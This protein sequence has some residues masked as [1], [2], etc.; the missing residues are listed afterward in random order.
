[1]PLGATNDSYIDQNMIGLVLRG[2]CVG[3]FENNLHGSVSPQWSDILGGFVEC[4]ASPFNHKFKN[5]HSMFD[6]DIPFGSRG[7]FFAMVKRNR[8]ILLDGNYQMNPMW[9]NAMF[10]EL[11]RIIQKSVESNR[12]AM[13]NAVIVA[14]AW[15][16]ANFQKAF[17][18]IKQNPRYKH[19]SRSGIR[20]VRYNHDLKKKTF[21]AATSYWFFSLEEVPNEVID[22][23]FRG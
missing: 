11:A 9:M 10:D 16:D 6:E 21:P 12:D 2:R 4:F 1:M 14:P 22:E 19:N 8:G 17:N 3:A 7:N 20:R 5:Y 15:K 23:L 13:I 18:R